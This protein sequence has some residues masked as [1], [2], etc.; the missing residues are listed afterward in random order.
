MI[1]EVLNQALKSAGSN[2]HNIPPAAPAS[3][4]IGIAIS[5]DE[6]P[7]IIAAQV[8]VIAPT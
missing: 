6:D 8:D 2:I 7:K 5:G 4:T 3:I 1:S